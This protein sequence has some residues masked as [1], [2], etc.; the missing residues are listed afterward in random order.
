[1]DAMVAALE[2]MDHVDDVHHVHVWR[3]DEERTALE[4][5]VAVTTERLEEADAVKHAIKR[6]LHD[7]FGIEH[8][9]LEMEFECCRGDEKA[10][11][12]HQ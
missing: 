8:A 7:D 2:R 1:M 6:R 12:R 11:I 9:T 4:A 3:L 10:V 5:H